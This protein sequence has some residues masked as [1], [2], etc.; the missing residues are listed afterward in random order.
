MNSDKKNVSTSTTPH[1]ES[2]RE[3][4]HRKI[5]SKVSHDLRTPLSLI[6]GAL[7]IY[8]RMKD[9]FTEEKKNTLIELAMQEAYRLDNFITNIL[10]MENLENKLVSHLQN[11]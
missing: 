3:Q 8:D 9:K 5:F 10:M 7:E 1:I 11:S 2:V 6:I 4:T